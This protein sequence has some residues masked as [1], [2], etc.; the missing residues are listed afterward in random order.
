MKHFHLPVLPAKVHLKKYTLVV[1]RTF[2]L[3]AL[4]FMILYP[5]IFK[6]SESLKSTA[7]SIDPTV[8]V[9]PKHPTLSHYRDVLRY[10]DFGRTFLNSF[11][12]TLACSIIQTGSCTLIAYGLARFD[13]PGKKLVFGCVMATFIIP[14]QTIL[15][16]LFFQFKYFS[17]SNIFSISVQNS[18]IS[19]TDSFWPFLIMSLTALGLKNGLYIFMLIQYFR[20]VPG[21]L[22]EAAYIDGCGPFATF[23]KIMLPPALPILVTVFLFAFVWQWNDNIYPSY[24]AST[25][26]IFGSVMLNVGSKVAGALGQNYNTSLMVTYNS[27]AIILQIIPLIIIYVFCQRFFV[28]SIERSGIVG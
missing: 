10:V 26:D 22:E 5:V 7:D 18:G 16:P 6:L 25:W 24:F 4:A 14:I 2:L 1:F 11:F 3:F 12:L 19:L 15:L 13:Y 8:F 17:L 9:I 28:Q 20:N 21:V 27:C 23:R